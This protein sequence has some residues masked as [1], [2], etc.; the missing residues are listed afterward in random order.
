MSKHIQKDTKGYFL[1]TNYYKYYFNEVDD[2]IIYCF[3]NNITIDKLD[4]ELILV[5]G[6]YINTTYD[7]PDSYIKT[8]APLLNDNFKKRI[9]REINIINLYE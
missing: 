5:G 7:Q 3:N 8:Y 1:K 4:Y 6:H 2:I 9:K